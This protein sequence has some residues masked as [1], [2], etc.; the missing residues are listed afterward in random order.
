MRNRHAIAAVTHALIAAA[1]L[2]ARPAQAQEI[3]ELPAED[4]LLRA[5]LEDVY[6]LGTMAGED[7]EQF[8]RLRR[9]GF[10][11]AGR[12]FVF[13]TQ[14][15]RIHVVAP[16]GEYR[17]TI[18][19]SGEGPGE[20]RRPDGLA[21][22]RDGRMVIA[23]LGHRAYHV[24]GADGEFERMVGM[25]P[26]EGDIRITDM[27]PHPGG[28]AI[29]T[30]VGAQ[31]LSGNLGT[32]GARTTPHTSRPVER[33][34]LTGDVAVKDTVAEGWLPG[35]GDQTSLPV[36]GQTNYRV[37]IPLPFGPRILPGVLPDGSVAF[38]D[39]SAYAIKIAR[40][41]EGV[42]RILRRPLEP[43]P[44]T[45]R[46]IEAEKERRLRDLEENSG[47]GGI[48][49]NGVRVA[50]N[51]D[52][53]RAR[54]EELEFFDEVSIVRG[55]KTDWTGGIWVQRHGEDP[56]DDDGPIDVLTMDGEYVGTY[57]A[58][59]I[60]MPDAFGPD[61]LVAFVETDELDVQTVVVRRLVR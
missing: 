18:G 27:Y 39:S 45:D 5:E 37:P 3:I 48:V 7:W 16:D 54:I 51:L 13:D 41:G 31:M 26:E 30:A 10:D 17:H 21:V 56:S 40:A 28:D 1:L 34:L 19:R 53:A 9:V 2:T 44:V 47:R 14:A 33:L 11:G 6:R 52:R 43:I 24:F 38:S 32:S 20:F 29:F 36:N 57:P 4:R 50:P 15:D 49:M 35:G 23:D 55:L 58:G 12:L 59:M 46:V 8:G 61:G 22:M 25:A 42:L 60:E